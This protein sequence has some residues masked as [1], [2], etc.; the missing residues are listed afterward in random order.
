MYTAL[1]PSREKKSIFTELAGWLLRLKRNAR[2]K[3][4]TDAKKQKVNNTICNNFRQPCVRAYYVYVYFFIL[5][6]PRCRCCVC[7]FFSVN[8][9]VASAAVDF[10]RFV[11]VVPF[12]AYVPL[13]S[14]FCP[15]HRAFYFHFILMF[16]F[17]AYIHFFLFL[18]L[19]LPEVESVCV[20]C[21]SVHSALICVCHFFAP[22][23]NSPR[24]TTKCRASSK[25][26][27]LFRFPHIFIWIIVMLCVMFFFCILITHI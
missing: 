18:R 7:Y 22:L 21:G 24:S 2:G 25:C 10:L 19:T 9:C 17:I 8:F 6:I 15:F 4:K 1:S 13:C 5:S 3:K 14:L 23:T 26:L 16:T 20:L 27:S 11:A 12:Y